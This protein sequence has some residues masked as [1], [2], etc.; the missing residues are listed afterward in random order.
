MSKGENYSVEELL[1]EMALNDYAKDMVENC[2][3]REKED[4]IIEQAIIQ[5]KKDNLRNPS[6]EEVYKKGKLLKPVALGYNGGLK[7]K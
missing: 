6:I 1:F 2:E 3:E 4:Q 5:H 7:W